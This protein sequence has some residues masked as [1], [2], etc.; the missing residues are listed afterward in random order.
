MKKNIVI[1]LL[2]L[3]TI[4]AY[5]QREAYNWYFGNGAGI[6]F[7][8]DGSTPNVLLNGMLSSPEGCAAMSDSTGNLLFYT[9]G[10]TVRNRNHA[11]MTNGTGLNGSG[12]ASQSSI[13][14]PNPSRNG[15]YYIFTINPN[16][17]TLSYSTVDINKNGGPGEIINK[18]TT[19]LSPVSEKLTATIA[20]NGY[21]VYLVT[22]GL[23]NNNFYAFKITSTGVNATPVIS[24]VGTVHKNTTDNAKGQMKISPNGRNLAITIPDEEGFEIFTFNAGN[25]NVE[26]PVFIPV[27]GYKPYGLEFSPDGKKLYISTGSVLFQYNIENYN[28]DDILNSRIEIARSNS[29]IQELQLAPDGKIY[30]ASDGFATIARINKPNATGA[31][32][33]FSLVS[34]NLINRN[35]ARGLPAFIQSYMTYIFVPSIISACQGEDV[36][37]NCTLS[38]D[39]SIAFYSWSGP[40]GFYSDKKNPLITNVSP[41]NSGYYKVQVSLGALKFTDSTYVKVMPAPKAKIVPDGPTTLC[42]GD[43]LKLFALPDNPEYSYHWSTGEEGSSIIVSSPGKYFLTTEANGCSSTD[44]I[45]ITVVPA[46]QPEIKA[47]G[48]KVICEGDTLIL[49]AYPKTNVNAY[50]WSTGDTTQSIIITKGGTYSVTVDKNGCLRTANIY[51]LNLE[52][53][54]TK[55]KALG[56]TSFCK[57]DSVVLVAEPQDPEYSYLWSTN[58]TTPYIVVKETGVITLETIARNGCSAKDT[59]EITSGDKLNVKIEKPEPPFCEGSSITLKVKPFSP[60]YKYLWSTGDTTANITINKSGKYFV[61]VRAPGGCEGN[62]TLDIHFSPVPVAKIEQGSQGEIC[63]GDSL[64]LN[65]ENF[66]PAN[67][68]FWSTGE[69]GSKITVK[70]PGLYSLIVINDAGCS[71]TATFE[72]KVNPAPFVNIEIIRPDILCKG[73]TA[74]LVA[75]HSPQS[76]VLWS[77]GATS[78]SIVINQTGLYSVKVE[79]QSQCVNFDTILVVF[80]PYKDPDIISNEG[81]SLCEGDILVLSSANEYY[82]Y[83]WNTGDTSRSIIVNTPGTYFLTITDTNGC[84]ATVSTEILK[85]ENKISGL[86]DINFG[87][88]LINSTKS[89]TLSLQNISR[90]TLVI[91]DIFILRDNNSYSVLKPKDT[92]KLGFNETFTTKVDFYPKEISHYPDSLVIAIE[93][94]CEENRF[95]KL[96]G[97]GTGLAEV[98]M[99]DTS[100]IIGRKNFRIPIRA[101]IDVLNQDLITLTYS[102]KIKFYADIFLP[103]LLTNGIIR[104]DTIIA[105]ERILT[106]QDSNVILTRGVS[107]LTELT[108]TILLGEHNASPLDIFDFHSDNPYLNINIRDGELKAEAVCLQDLSMVS[109][110]VAASITIK[111]NPA[112]NRLNIS[113]GNFTGNN[114]TLSIYSTSG[115]LIEKRD[116]YINSKNYALQLDLSNYDSGN[117]ILIVSGGPYLFKKLFSIIK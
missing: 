2:I 84:E 23:G 117:Y 67:S 41:A 6:T 3:S 91:S 28:Y 57:G 88:V 15:I 115:K 110:G 30:A 77:T 70:N 45:E 47:I 63:E 65:A 26:N 74:M 46:F 114:Y 72:L 1:L 24:L 54:P 25:G 22:H 103:D 113:L 80:N 53:P 99:P 21:D 13:I 10:A 97:H 12:N 116:I 43:S 31:N 104:H 85:A 94:P 105:G 42:F 52:K 93:S 89:E 16:T 39:E 58:E 5:S 59:I 109:P 40:G 36:Q 92:V 29:R 86:E 17:R 61:N 34:V 9:D 20:S 68:Y 50:Y 48:P 102:A 82:K 19:I 32:V 56:P 81:F 78:D 76:T 106:I 112:N 75:H 62:D 11:I 111:P 98:S 79:N 90:D 108:G 60:N 83:L 51:I 7:S 27:T 37:L 64:V 71:D 44:S 66:N 107:V 73:D 8:P 96:E 87:N 33:S 14:I 101:R 69:Q 100:G 55:I 95:V 38:R 35:S 18:N 4:P 49:E